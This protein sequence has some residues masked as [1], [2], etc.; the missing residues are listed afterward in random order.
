MAHPSALHPQTVLAV[1]I[2]LA[3]RLFSTAVAET[4]P[5]SSSRVPTAIKLGRTKHTSV[6]KDFEQ[7]GVYWTEEPGWHTDFQLRNNLASQELVVTPALRFSD[8]AELK[9]SAVTIPS[10][11][12]ATVSLHEAMA[13]S[14][15][16]FNTS[17][18]SVVL[19]YRAPVS[20]ALNAV[21]MIHLEGHPVGFHIDASL[22]PTEW[23]RGSREGIWWLPRATATDYLVLTNTADRPLETNLVLRDLNGKSAQRRIPIPAR[24]TI[25]LS[26]RSL[27]QELHL[28]G[29]Y[30]GI[31]VDV[32]QGAAYL[33]TF[34]VIFDEVTGSAA[35]MKMFDHDPEASAGER[36]WGGLKDWTIRAPMMAL[37]RPDPALGFPADTQLQPLV[38]LR[39]ASAQRVSRRC[40][41]IGIPHPVPERHRP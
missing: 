36:A 7:Y 13:Q 32:A 29:A 26:V 35:V 39:N 17:Y 1:T 11:D 9:L 33:D 31:T 30:G 27:L 4:P 14:A 5:A 25:R 3:L 24:Q 34:H 19:R 10:G 15:A 38:F 23:V 41:S 21:A 6:P 28:G 22:Q 18:G 37:T 16:Q 12:V 2:L 20:K 8:G 40:I